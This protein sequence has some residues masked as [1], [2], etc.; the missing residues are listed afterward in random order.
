MGADAGLF[1][2][3]DNPLIEGGG[4]GAALG[5]VGDGDV[6][7][8]VAS[9]V[10]TGAHGIG[11]DQHA[12]EG[13]RHVFGFEELGYGQHAASFRRSFVL[14]RMAP[15]GLRRPAKRHNFFGDGEDAGLA[16]DGQ[17]A[18][19]GFAAEPAGPVE[20][21]E[22]ERTVESVADERFGDETG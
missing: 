22:I 5:F 8:E 4:D 9:G 14:F 15:V 20:A 10:Q 1:A 2:G 17:E 21:A 6:A 16:G 19:M 13:E 11:L 3:V 7:D 18:V 12:V